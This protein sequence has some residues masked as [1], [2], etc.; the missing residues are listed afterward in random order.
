MSDIIHLLPDSV[1]NQIAAGEVIQRPASVLKELVENAIDAGA[2]D[3]QIVVKDGGRTLIQV[4]DNGKGMSETDAR[5]AFERHATSKIS[6]AADL[7]ALRTMGFRGEALASI[8]AVAQVELRTRRAEDELGTVVEIAGSRVFVQE[9]VQTAAGTSFMVKNL[10]FNVPARRRF[11]KSDNVE[12]T[13]LLNEFYRIALVNPHIAFTYY[14]GSEEIFNL[15][16]SNTKLRIENIFGKIS[17]KRWEQQLLPVESNTTLVKIYGYIG[18]PEFAQKSA[19]QYFFVNGRYM[20][21]PYFHKAVMVAYDRMLASGENP[22]YFI[23]FDVDPETIDI[24]IH[25]TKTEIKFENEQAIWP[26]L[27]ATIKETLGKFNVVPSIDFDTEGA[28][29]IPVGKDL[30]DIRPPQ[31]N[32]NPNYNPFS[33]SSSYKRPALDWE[34]LYE[35]ME[36]ASLKHQTKFDWLKEDDYT[37]EGETNNTTLLREES[38][39]ST[40]NADTTGVST[41]YL[42]LKNRFVLTSVKSGLLVID[43]QRAHFRIL[44]DQFIKQIEQKQG[45]SQQLLFPET[46]DLTEEEKLLFSEIHPD[47]QN[48]GF[49]IKYDG[50]LTCQVKGIPSGIEAGTAIEILHEV[51]LKACAAESGAIAKLHETLAATLAEAS[52]LKAGQHLTNIE[53]ADL[54]DKLFA[55]SNHNYA[56]DGK[57]ILSILTYEELENRFK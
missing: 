55:A 2:T 10:F 51:L 31:T 11:L 47:L 40:E 27:S 13:H 53:M 49:D 12:K 14:D 48:V 17:K 7:F 41:E 45:F 50:G 35:G 56:P 6:D 34:K 30:Q 25:P 29:D 9:P 16:V 24:N 23:Y 43:Q 54:I 21:H 22:N 57:K 20:R 37:E 4:T 32:F 8:A 26:I 19:N 39:I 33:Q 15:P 42:Q 3:I 52:S 28:P 36:D 46:L 5:M 1:A 38:R 44:F 18:K